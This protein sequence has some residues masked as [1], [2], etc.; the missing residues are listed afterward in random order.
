MERKTG[1]ICCAFFIL[2]SFVYAQENQNTAAPKDSS[3][4]APF[5][6]LISDTSSSATLITASFAYQFP[7]GD[8]ARR[9]KSSSSIGGGLY[10]KTK[11]NLLLGGEA[12]FI[13]GGTPKENGILDSIRTGKTSE[14]GVIDGNGQVADI[15]MYER[16]FDWSVKVGKIFPL[17]STNMNS[18]LFF[19]FGAGFLQHK[20]RIENLG[21]RA[22]QVAPDY[23]EGYDRLSNGMMINE[24]AGFFFMGD[25]RLANFYG[26][27]D[28]VQGF[29]TGRRYNFDQMHLDDS[30]RFDMLIGIRFGWMIPV[31]SRE[32]DDSY[33]F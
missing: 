29:T 33:L 15:R 3:A 30:K 7:G 21:N 23:R 14:G 22:P 16:G 8:M 2:H 12:H 18:G 1:F 27:L 9:F 24:T 5:K 10:Y 19:T 6:R 4:A 31:K 25:K 32:P 20:I 28:L 11:S 13:F 17:H 26:A